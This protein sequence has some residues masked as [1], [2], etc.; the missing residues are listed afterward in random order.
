V[1]QILEIISSTHHLQEAVM[2]KRRGK[3][4]S[5]DAMVKF[6]M[7]NYEIPTKKDVERLAQKLDRIEKLLKN[8]GV[9]SSRGRTKGGRTSEGRKPRGRAGSTAVDFVL[10]V[11]KEFNQGAGLQEIK[12]RTGYGD[13]KIR[14]ILFRLYKDGRIKRV[15]R[16]VYTAG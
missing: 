12:S 8:S 6:F 3:P 4:V 10:E 14:N 7:Q 13:K 5:F 9:G 1:H 15:S 2:V 11:I 16:G